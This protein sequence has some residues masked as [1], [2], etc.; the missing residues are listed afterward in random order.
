MIQ[1]EYT[2]NASNSRFTTSLM[3][4]QY[5]VY[6]SSILVTSFY[7]KILENSNFILEEFSIPYHA[8]KDLLDNIT[9]LLHT[10]NYSIPASNKATCDIEAEKK[11]ILWPT[12]HVFSS[13]IKKAYQFDQQSDM[14]I[15]N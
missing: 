9:T 8:I 6:Y 13:V 14:K 2:R 5:N 15:Q 4:T 3:A 12:V 1:I 7:R 10:S 11:K